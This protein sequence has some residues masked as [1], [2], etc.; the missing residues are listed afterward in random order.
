MKLFV[1]NLSFNTTEGE[2]REL[3][4]PYEPVMEIIRP[5]NRE[6]GKPRGFAF[7]SLDDQEKAE[8]AIKD[9][10]D[11]KFGGRVLK[12]NEAEDRGGQPPEP[13]NPVKESE[14]RVD[15]RPKDK[16]GKKVVYKSI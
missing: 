6:T 9:L 16:T 3:F 10:D 1:G 7:V 14:K 2:I 13:F 8:Q 15:D 5:L 11:S 4:E 12:V